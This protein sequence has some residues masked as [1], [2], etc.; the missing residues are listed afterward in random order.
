MNFKKLAK[1]G[2]FSAIQLIMTFC[3]QP[4][5][6]VKI[7][8]LETA[9]DISYTSVTL[10]GEV[11]D[12]GSKDIED[13]GILI[14]ENSTPRVGNA[15]VESL[16]PLN[17]KGPF[18]ISITGLA[19]NTLYYFRAFVTVNGTDIFA[20]AIFSFRTKN[21]EAATVTAGVISNTTMVSASLNGEVTS[22][23]GEAVTKRGLCWSVNPNPVVSADTTAC[24]S[25]TGTF[26][27]NLKNLT[28]GTQY[29]VRTFA[30]NA[31]GTSYSPA[32][33]VFTTHN[34]PAVTTTAVTSITN[35]GA[36]SGGNVTSEGGV[37][38]SARGVVWG[39][40]AGPTI[41]LPTKTSDGTGAGTF[42]STLT[43]LTP[44]ASYFIR[45][46]AT[47]KYGTSYGTELQ[48]T[49]TKPSDVTTMPVETIG[50]T[51]AKIKGSVN[52]NGFA[53]NVYFEYGTTAL[54][55]LLADAVPS[56]V[57]GNSSVTVSAN[58][59]G[60]QPGIEYHYRL[61]AVNAG[62]TSTG[63]D[64]TFTT[65]TSPVAVTGAANTITNTSSV[66][67]GNVN[68]NGSSTTVTF[69]YGITPSYGSIATGSPSPLTG[70]ISTSVTGNLA[71]LI[72]GT[73]Y[74]YRVKAMSVGG[75]AYGD[76][77][78]FTT[79]RPPD[80]S[81]SAAGSVSTT[82][83]ILNGAV[84]AYDLSTSV[85]FEYG[86]T[87]SY[88]SVA[89]AA[90]SPV[91]GSTATSVSKAITGLAPG[92]TYHFR[93]KAES[94]AGIVYGSDLTFK[95]LQGPSATTGSASNV[96]NTSATLNGT[97]NANESSTTVSFEYGPTT[98]YGTT[99]NAIP[100]TA[101]GSSST[102]VSYNLTGLSTGVIYHFR[103]VAVSA[104]GTTTGSDATFTTTDSPVPVTGAASTIANTSAVLTGEVNANG[105]STTV[106]FELG[107]TT[108]YGQNIAA[109]PSPV[110]G[111]TTTSVSGNATGLTQGTL[112]HYRV[113]AVSTA[114][115][116][117]GNDITFTTTRPPDAA[118]TAASSITTT[119]ATLNGLVTAYDLPTTVN[120]EYG[121]TTSYG[122]TVLATQSPVTGSLETPVTVQLTGLTPGTTYHFRVKA[123]SSAGIIYGSDLTFKNPVPP[124]ATTTAATAVA[125]T[126]ATLNATL[127]ANGYTMSTYFEYGPT[128]AYGTTINGPDVMGSTPGNWAEPITGLI[129][130]TTYHYRVV[131]TNS[132]GTT[133]GSDMTFTTTEPPVALTG[134]A[135]Y[136][137]STTATLG[138]TVNAKG[139]STTITFEYGT[140]TAYGLTATA[141]ESPLTGSTNNSVTAAISSLT[142]ATTYHFRV[143]AV[144]SG[145]TVYGN[146]GTFTTTDVPLTI[147]DFDGNV[148]NT[149]QIGT[150]LWMKEN[151][152]VTHYSN[153]DGILQITDNLAWNTQNSGAFTWM[154]ND[155]SFKDITGALYNWYTAADVRNVCPAGWHVPSKIDA[156]VMFDYLGGSTVAGGKMKEAGTSHWI[157]PNTGGDNS[158]GFSGFGGGYRSYDGSFKDYGVWGG[159]WTAIDC[160]SSA[161]YLYI[162]HN[163]ETLVNLSVPNNSPANY[164]YS[165]RC[166][167]NNTCLVETKA[168]TE[169]TTAGAKLN[170]A[171]NPN[172]LETSVSFEYGITTLYGL[173]KSAAPSTLTG[174]SSSNVSL[175]LTSLVPGTT[176]HYRVKATNSNGTTYGSDMTFTYLAYGLTY[177]GGLIFYIDATGQHGLVCAPSN[178]GTGAYYFGCPGTI[179]GAYGE[180]LSASSANTTTI[181]TACSTS[182]IAARICYDLV[183]NGYDDWILPSK[184][185]LQLMY[186]NLHVNGIGNFSSGNYISSSEINETYFWSTNFQNGGTFANWKTNNAWARAIRWF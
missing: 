141:A 40:T 180:T 4:E 173:E 15:R 55:G 159:W 165:I 175:L 27:G 113:K 32:D 25:G 110:T 67:T 108:S 109:T 98:S 44:G 10:K 93:V 121:S 166:I 74:H 20:D 99:V 111:S 140:T 133:R 34:Y 12:L 53:A 132:I 6:I 18:E 24:G 177:Q 172:G 82:A 62:G 144:S 73:T 136:V 39:T 149:V 179:T 61:K 117:Y 45:A 168:A 152:K 3:E 19:K 174:S 5:R 46:Y 57:S 76:D 35:T 91:S 105:S 86:T 169:I 157:T 143:K 51:T 83:A 135:S 127:N 29:Y 31:K 71:G 126:S 21:T 162:I 72:Q 7:N 14:S 106:S 178:L 119:G 101:T 146:D 42:A 120:F 66:L 54:Y 28:H 167:K 36:T 184:E 170:A 81:T 145:G 125:S 94:A 65:T 123:E 17:K 77:A 124:S 183:L 23:G 52:P 163:T 137:G 161:P 185:A 122:M 147:T 37:T 138:G 97:V 158:S 130:G 112:Y 26:A 181:I 48:F 139:L 171:V 103:V 88:G 128:T 150:Q 160:Y 1:V 9:V 41:E 33:V 118:T 85:K 68:P 176:Y 87:T 64:M 8:T 114:G 153:G 107:T 56:P 89:D 156:T 60:L 182:S 70:N 80:A 63:A 142:A 131:A 129:P 102:S 50:N 49:A 148:Y 13:H 2:L 69:E 95:T 92:T 151:L 11:T 164:G 30:I 58:L 154:L 38:V 16:G 59:T 90:Q 134:S 75:T 186:L 100:G 155:L 79:T 115:T 78:T 84:T 22:D 116:S 43:G 104:G 96:A 47:N